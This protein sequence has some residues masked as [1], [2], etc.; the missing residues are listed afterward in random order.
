MKN[1][2]LTAAVVFYAGFNT[3]VF[4]QKAETPTFVGNIE[5]V[6]EYKLS[7]GMNVL[8][9]PDQSQSNM[10]VNIIY[11]VGSKDEGY[12][13]KGM[14]HL[15]EHM[16]F[17][18]TKNLG[19]I[20]KQLSDKGGVA[21][22]TTYYD[23]TNYY[24]IFPSNDENLKWSLQMEADRM[25]N[26][27]I[28]QTDLDKEFSVVRNEFEI[29][30]NNPTRVMIQNVFSNAYTWHNYGN[31]TIGSKEDIERVKAPTLRKFY[32]KYYQPDNATLVIAGKFDE[33]NALKYVSDY[34]SALPKPTRELGVTYTVE[35]AQNGEKY[36]EIKRNNDQQII[37]A[38]YH[39]AAF[40]DK[41]YAALSALNEILTADPSGYLYKG[42]V[43]GGNA[44]SVWAYYIPAR[45]PGMIYYN[46]DISKEKNLDEATKLVK[47]QLDKIAT[48]NY[49]EED[50]N[51]AKSKLLKD[52]ATEKN[53][54][55]NYAIGFT[56][57]VGTG[58]YKLAFVYR[59]NVENLKLEDIKRVA[60]KYFKN[61]NR[62]L[63]VFRPSS[64]EERVLP[65]EFRSEQIATLTKD[66]KGKALEKEPA[67]FET[68]IANVK[69]N[70]TEG[71]LS[72]GMK[73]GLIN[74]EL[75]GDKVQGSFRFRIGNEK[76]LQGKSA[77]AS[78]TASLL[79][80]GTKTR[81]KEQI[82]D[83]LDQMK[84][85]LNF[86][87]SGQNLIVQFATYKNDF[88]KVMAI[89]Q[90]VLSNATFPENELTKTIAENNTYLDGQLKDPEAIAYNE[91]ARLSSP[92]PKTSI[93]YTS[94]LEEEIADNKKVTRA[95]VVDFYNNVLG[96][97]NGAGT[98]IGSLDAKS[99]GSELEK[100]FGK[101]TAK[102]KF[103]EVKPTLFETKKV[104]KN[105][106]TPDK[107]NA[108]ALGTSSFTMKQDSPEYPALVLANE[109]LGSGG[110]LSARLPMRLREKDGISYGVGSYLNVPIT[111]DVS[112]WNYY[113]YL[114]PTKR[115]AVESAVKDEV[116][117]AL[118]TGFTQEELD[119][120]KKSYANIRTTSLG[121]ENTLINLE[122]TKLLFGVPLENY[123]ELNAKIQNLKLSEVN[124]VL[125]KY[126]SLDKVT[127]IYAGDFNKK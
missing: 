39:A 60:A 101:F 11:N 92:Y 78:M 52:I 12:G 23:R 111:N 59:D 61:N 72:N 83:Q 65:T 46:F 50:L 15:L 119:S 125:K 33:K 124:A 44:S 20:K 68:S 94:T 19:D 4:S 126:I 122:N 40:A 62:T 73:Y 85:S 54:T 18:S 9:I 118:K 55:I 87:T 67:P 116:S 82:Q 43:D 51:R 84:S 66:Y 80:S 98:I 17:K 77:V 14:A 91:L 117:K 81:T 108:V 49:T 22:G 114:N 57:I 74:K 30:E 97:S 35:P 99:A 89:M 10:V 121:M 105:I 25:I 24:E 53:N 115:D 2:L 127:S 34:F 100:T 45:D 112:S 8:L 31:S 26:A 37:A 3:P 29:G 38:G 42:L 107:E 69:K 32:E 70:L 106:I 5:G 79:K 103:E 47:A 58:S 71:T 41:D 75:K 102:S 90:D 95:Q 63:G 76:D 93:F 123:D 86:Y 110:F 64:N 7:N 120:N 27:T 109:I 28:L 13:E 1:F 88:P 104:D 48:I 96:A 36:F 56:E 21:N 6:K 16:L 113:A